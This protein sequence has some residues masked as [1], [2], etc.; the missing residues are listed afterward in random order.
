MTGVQTCAL[1]ILL[2]LL[3]AHPTPRGSP[4]LPGPPGSQ[5]VS[6]S[7]CSLPQ[8][9]LSSEPSTSRKPSG[10]AQEGLLLAGNRQ[11]PTP[12]PPALRVWNPCAHRPSGRGGTSGSHWGTAGS[13][14]PALEGLPEP[15]PSR[16]AGPCS[17]CDT[18]PPHRGWSGGQRGGREPVEWPGAAP[19]LG[20]DPALEPA[21]I[22]AP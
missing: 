16:A 7:A 5:P 15:V 10:R 8:P 6:T 9:S 12:T 21:F 17:L 20:A 4:V 14:A 2:L 22:R 3:C 13:V 11:A 1:P 18:H 19:D